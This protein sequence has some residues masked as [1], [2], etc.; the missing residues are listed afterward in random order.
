MPDKSKIIEQLEEALG[1]KP[2]ESSADNQNTQL[3]TT[4]NSND[5]HVDDYE[6]TKRTNK[7]LYKLG[8]SSLSELTELARETSD[9][10]YFQVLSELLRSMNSVSNS[11]V[12]AAK[13]KSEI[14]LNKSKIGLQKENIINGK[15]TQNN[16]TIFVGSTKDLSKF[17]EDTKADVNTIEDIIIDNVSKD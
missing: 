7:E 16:Q 8:F 5:S 11:I 2:I 13:T 1:I 4:E 9:V 17:L 12:G 15:L 6:F 10:K 14:E 3:I